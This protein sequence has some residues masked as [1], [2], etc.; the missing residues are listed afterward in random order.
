MY[1]QETRLVDGHSNDS[2]RLEVL[3]NDEWGTVCDEEWDLNDAT[4]ACRQLG[5]PAAIFTYRHAHFGE[6]FGRIWI[7]DVQCKGTELS[8]LECNHERY[9]KPSCNHTGDVGVL[10][11][12]GFDERTLKETRCHLHQICSF[13]ENHTCIYCHDYNQDS[14]EDLSQ[15]MRYGGSYRGV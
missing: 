14:A 4:V 7:S 10:C 6:G 5:F 2:G 15:M 3:I 11:G 8:L 9:Q 12:D 13:M 1:L